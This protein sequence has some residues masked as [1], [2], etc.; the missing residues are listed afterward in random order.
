MAGEVFLISQQELVRALALLIDDSTFDITGR[1]SLAEELIPNKNR[2]SEVAEG[3]PFNVRQ[4]IKNLVL[5]D[6]YND[7]VLD[8]HR[9]DISRGKSK[10][11]VFDFQCNFVKQTFSER[12]FSKR[13]NN[14]RI[15]KT[16]S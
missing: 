8:T 12:F 13:Y 7:T 2:Q 14:I 6:K 4:L 15:Q 16:Y 5:V 11:N 10:N 3:C 9:D 1:S